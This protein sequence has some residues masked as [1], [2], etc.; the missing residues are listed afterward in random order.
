MDGRARRAWARDDRSWADED[1]W[2]IENGIADSR[3]G[4]ARWSVI[5]NNAGG[6]CQGKPT[7]DSMVKMIGFGDCR[8]DTGCGLFWCF[9][10]VSFDDG[11]DLQ[12]VRRLDTG[13][14]G[15][16]SGQIGYSH[17]SVVKG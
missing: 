15:T 2:L 1:W 10:F 11:E 14:I 7:V 6:D 8:E 17:R 3:R 9:W 4:R 12:A 13:S 5:I 16:G